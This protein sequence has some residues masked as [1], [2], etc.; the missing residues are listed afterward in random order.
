MHKSKNGPL[1]LLLVAALTSSLILGC[2]SSGDDKKGD[3]S[4]GTPNVVAGKTK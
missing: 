4:K 2:G 3:A 1:L